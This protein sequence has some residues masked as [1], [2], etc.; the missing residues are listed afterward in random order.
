MTLPKLKKRILHDFDTEIVSIV[1]I[2]STPVIDVRVFD[3]KFNIG[4][5]DVTTFDNVVGVIDGGGTNEL[6][7]VVLD[8]WSDE[9]I[10]GAII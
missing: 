6:F 9:D 10:L 1:C 4:F 3:I 7:D 5:V 2:D 8:K